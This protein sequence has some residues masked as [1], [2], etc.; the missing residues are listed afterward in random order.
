MLTTVGTQRSIRIIGTREIQS[1]TESSKT[2][3][4]SIHTLELELETQRLRI[5]DAEDF[6]IS[7]QWYILQRKG[8]R[9]SPAAQEFKAFVIS[10]AS[11]FIR[12]PE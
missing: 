7:R 9:L 3:I 10:E 12:L 5:L 8:K 6:P 2:G 11:Q 4:V 1:E